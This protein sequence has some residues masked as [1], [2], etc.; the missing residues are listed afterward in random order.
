MIHRV[1]TFV[2]TC[3]GYVSVRP[4]AD[5]DPESSWGFAP[6][7]SK[8]F[9]SGLLKYLAPMVTYPCQCLSYVCDRSISMSAMPRLLIYV[10]VRL[11]SVTDLSFSCV[12]T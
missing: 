11:V 10:S 6:L 7:F 5:P 4:V 9:F 8:E 1:L 12:C 2:I 3:I